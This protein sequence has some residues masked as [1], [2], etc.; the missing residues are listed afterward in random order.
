MDKF[1]SDNL[2]LSRSRVKAMIDKG[3]ITSN[4]NNKLMKVKIVNSIELYVKN[5]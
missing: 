2:N 1:I 4:I 5:L 3:Y